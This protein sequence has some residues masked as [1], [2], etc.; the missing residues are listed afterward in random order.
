M[1]D[2]VKTADRRLKAILHIVFFLSGIATVLIG[3]LLPILA[4]KFSL[5]DLQLG[6]FFPVQLAGSL[7][8]TLLS[9]WFGRKERLVLASLIGCLLMG[10]GISLMTVDLLAVC[11]AGFFINGLGVGIT[12]PAINLTILEMNPLRSAAALSVLN[13][14]WGVGAI[15]SK[16]FVDRTASGTSI[17]LTCVLLA[18]PMFIS[19]A[20]LL[21]VSLKREEVSLPDI[22]DGLNGEQTPIWRTPIA[23][24]IAGFNFIHIGFESGMGGWITTY[25][26]RI[27]NAPVVHLLSPTFL[28]FLFFVVG[29]GV[30]PVFFRVLDENRVLLLSLL[31]ILAGMLV[32]IYAPDLVTLSI[33]ASVAGFGTSSVFPTNVS[34]FSATFGPEALK[35][36]TPLF[37]LGTSGAAVITW[38]IGY[39]SNQTGSLRS[40]MVVLMACIILL[41][42]L[43]TVLM[44]SP[45][46][47]RRSV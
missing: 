29:R 37:F 20:V 21:A 4:R 42:L 38:L 35:R 32:V 23:W 41:I 10:T 47:L 1:T 43:Q 28:F 8:G 6:Y 31:V 19:A 30:A 39:L 17:S 40:G 26:E 25:S 34:R 46:A 11:L 3:Q 14:C 7:T 5:N 13:F 44:F 22:D 33:G 18:V 45:R 2:D 16:P 12:L 36:A 24:A 9:N 27:E 15:V